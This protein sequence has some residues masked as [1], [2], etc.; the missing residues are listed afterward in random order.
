MCDVIDRRAADTTSGVRT[1]S[2]A[3]GNTADDPPYCSMSR[4]FGDGEVKCPIHV[5]TPVIDY[6]YQHSERFVITLPVFRSTVISFHQYVPAYLCPFSI[7]HMLRW[8]LY[9]VSCR[10]CNCNE[11]YLLTN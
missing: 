1:T 11:T 8:N 5:T 10:C 4:D 6:N 2:G 9:T 7:V 3:Y